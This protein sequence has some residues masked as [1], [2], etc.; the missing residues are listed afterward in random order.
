M[1]T[2]LASTFAFCAAA[3]SGAALLPVSAS[4][5]ENSVEIGALT[6]RQTDRTNL[7]VFSEA[8]FD[9]TFDPTNGENE[10]YNGKTTKIGVD[11][12]AYKVET[13]IWYVF[14]PSADHNPGALQGDYGGASV[15]AAVGVGGGV[16]VLV[17]GL[18]R[19]FTLQ[20]AAVSGQTGVGIAAGIEA[21][22]LTYTPNQ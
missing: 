20:P 2:K 11:L 14:A 6:C 1:P 15:D 19:S 9:C 13:L 10:K 5:E 12:T 8:T 21:F 16:H 4:A 22:E 3:L 17:G 7:V 18:Q